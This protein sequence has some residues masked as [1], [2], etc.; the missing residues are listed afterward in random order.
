MNIHL[1]GVGWAS[2]FAPLLAA[3]KTLPQLTCNLY[4]SRNPSFPCQS[5][6]EIKTKDPFV[7]RFLFKNSDSTLAREK[8]TSA[9]MM[10]QNDACAVGRI[11]LLSLPGQEPI[12]LAG[13]EDDAIGAIA[14]ADEH[15]VHIF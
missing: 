1:Y 12:L 8:T 11:V 9:M 6:G 7:L 15:K 10:M 4:I 13:R 5:G 2:F 14:L 3:R